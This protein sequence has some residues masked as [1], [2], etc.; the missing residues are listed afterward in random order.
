MDNIDDFKDFDDDRSV[1]D[2]N[3]D[4]EMVH[5]LHFGGFDEDGDEKNEQGFEQR[6]K[7][8]N[9]IYAELIH[10]SKKLKFLR[11][12]QQ[13]ENEEKIQELDDDFEE[14]FDLLAKKYSFLLVLN[15]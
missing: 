15:I 9:E 2:D 7:S 6:K 4:A 10:K 8:K 1:S 5:N 3:I 11:Q 14:I 13:E 12:Q